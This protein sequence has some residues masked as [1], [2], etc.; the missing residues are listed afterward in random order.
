MYWYIVTHIVFPAMDVTGY[1]SLLVQHRF[2][3]ISNVLV[4][5]PYAVSFGKVEQHCK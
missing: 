4:I 1:C 3:S 2:T 5:E